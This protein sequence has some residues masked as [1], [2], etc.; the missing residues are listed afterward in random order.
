LVHD[1]GKRIGCGATMC[2]LSRIY[3]SEIYK[4]D[5]IKLYDYLK[6][7]YSDMLSKIIPIKEYFKDVKAIYLNEIDYSKFLN[8]I[9]LEC[10]SIDKIVRVYCIKTYKGLG[11]VENNILKRFIIE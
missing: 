1:I 5:C 3:S 8:G 9:K 11:K 4:R 6:L 7:E 10:N 2:E